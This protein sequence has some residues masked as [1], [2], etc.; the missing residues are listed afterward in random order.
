MQKFNHSTAQPGP[1]TKASIE[2]EF[3]GWRVTFSGDGTVCYARGPGMAE[4]K[5]LHDDNLTDLR[6]QII[7][8]CNLLH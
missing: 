7:A 6:Q 8:F 3:E 2:A 4:H 5:A 1:V